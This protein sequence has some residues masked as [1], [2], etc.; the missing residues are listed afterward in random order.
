M[1][2]EKYKS[3][4]FDCDGVVL[5]SNKVK[6]SAFYQAA[7]PYGE[8]AASSLVLYHIRNGGVSRYKKF[9][10]F[11]ENIVKP[12]CKGPNI[13]SLLKAYS[14][15]VWQGLLNC[16]IAEGLES[17]RAKTQHANWLI[18]SGGDQEELRRLFIQRDIFRYFDGGV[19]GSPDSKQDIL[20]RELSAGNIS[21]RAVLIGDSR[22]DYQAAS[23]LALDFIFCSGWSEVEDP[24]SW[25]PKNARV[26]TAVK[27][28]LTY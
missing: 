17:L 10:H 5:N 8:D 9:A 11:L 25:L 13:D 16:E 14:D 4:V 23:E 22:Y 6:T 21:S 19:F 27:D 26:I 7:L 18:A 3:I 24:S 15:Q 1:I 12:G 28:I 20:F 2:L